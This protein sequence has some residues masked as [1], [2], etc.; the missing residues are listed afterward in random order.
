MAVELEVVFDPHKIPLC[1]FLEGEDG[2]GLETKIALE[3]LC[4]LFH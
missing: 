4:N 1:G 2:S 3:L